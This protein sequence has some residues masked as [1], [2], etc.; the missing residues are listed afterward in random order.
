MCSLKRK[1][2]NMLFVSFR[3]T[4]NPTSSWKGLIVDK[5]LSLKGVIC[6]PFPLFFNPWFF[7][8]RWFEQLKRFGNERA[9]RFINRFHNFYNVKSGSGYYNTNIDNV[10]VT[11]HFWLFFVCLFVC[12]LC[13]CFP[14]F[15]YPSLWV[16]FVC[17]LFYGTTI[18]LWWS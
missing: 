18:L 3:E 6:Q 15:A 14:L 7:S 12:L 13:V 17:L 4:L 16:W 2:I 11:L 8:W 1:L 5:G 10:W 9:I